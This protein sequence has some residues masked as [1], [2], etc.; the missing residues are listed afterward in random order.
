M[1]KLSDA[2]YHG[3]LNWLSDQL[4][5]SGTTIKDTKRK[6]WVSKDIFANM[7]E[8]EHQT[9]VKAGIAE[10]IDNEIQ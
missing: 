3:Y 2:W 4:T 1:G 7:Y 5:R 6:K 10:I 8:N 9:M